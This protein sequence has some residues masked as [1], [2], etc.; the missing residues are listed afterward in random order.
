MK[1]KFLLSVLM[2][3]LMSTSAVMAQ[4]QKF[5]QYA[6]QDMSIS[7][8]KKT[9]SN[10][11]RVIVS[12][13]YELD[14]SLF[15]MLHEQYNVVIK[16]DRKLLKKYHIL[17]VSS[18][19][20]KELTIQNL[21][22]SGYFETVEE[23]AVFE[24]KSTSAVLGTNDPNLLNQI[25]L[26]S[27]K[28]EVF[29][30]GYNSVADAMLKTSQVKKLRIA[31]LDT[32]YIQHEDMNVTEGYKFAT[33]I[34]GQRGSSFYD[35]TVYEDP[36]NTANTLSCYDG[37]G[38]KVAGIIS[39]KSNNN[40]GVAGV[41][42]SDIVM[43]RVLEQDC[44]T[45]KSIGNLSDLA[46]AIEWVSEESVPNIPKISK[47]VDIINLSLGGIVNTGCPTYLQLA[48]DNAISKGIV[49]VSSSGNEN[50]DVLS[51]AP[52]GCEN[53]IT[54]AANDLSGQKSHYSNFGNRVTVSALGDGFTTLSPVENNAGSYNLTPT[55]YNVV[56]DE[57]NISNGDKGT[58]FSAAI[59]S[60][61]V[62]LVM[63]KYPSLVDNGYLIK[64]IEQTSTPHYYA[65]NGVDTDC[66]E[67]R[68]G[69][70]VF[71]ASSLMDF[72]DRVLGFNNQNNSFY[73]NKNS[74]E[75]GMMLKALS[76]Y[77]DV[78]SVYTLSIT[79]NNE[80]DGTYYE[81]YSDDINSSNWET[82]TKI[83]ETTTSPTD[84]SLVLKDLDFVK[85]K[86]GVRYCDG[87]DCYQLKRINFDEN[88]L[89]QYCV[90]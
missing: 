62:G 46:E 36:D 4:T 77:V 67:G 6:I 49:V 82:K 75:D 21:E 90:K 26:N 53:V 38:T 27:Q 1:N 7:E 57:N 41:I 69:A 31:V 84:R 17:Y 89:P 70:G 10:T 14:A 74:C 29:G 9:Y 81:V 55:S 24:T 40:L 76:Y 5:D 50:V 64:A 86:Y 22:K 42:D 61:S 39:A 59:V 80:I 63:Q 56:S 60:G 30:S 45:G 48:I 54:V 47:K 66:T 23:D 20:D 34:T 11:F 52:A 33:E 35:H 18:N 12:S 83:A 88:T 87:V 15:S 71:N 43:V 51:Y 19:E 2:A 16:Y 28:E 79:N 13:D 44:K 72:S 25:Y 32:G 73:E 58:S 68:C 65:G 8:F 3:S 37:H 85:N 78:C